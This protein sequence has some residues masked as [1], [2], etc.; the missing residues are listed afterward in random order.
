[1]IPLKGQT[2]P[3]E[4]DAITHCWG[5]KNILETLEQV[6]DDAVVRLPL[7]RIEQGYEGI[8]QDLVELGIFRLMRDGRI[9]MPDVYRIGYGLGRKGGVKLIR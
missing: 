6:N 5:Q 7:R 3:C 4:F 9:N 2:V 1:M 8:K